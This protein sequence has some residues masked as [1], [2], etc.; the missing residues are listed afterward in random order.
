LHR[1]RLL[2]PF[3]VLIFLYSLK[4]HARSRLYTTV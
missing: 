4:F 3:L 1:W 2:F